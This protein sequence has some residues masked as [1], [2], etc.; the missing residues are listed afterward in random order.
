MNLTYLALLVLPPLHLSQV[1]KLTV[2]KIRVGNWA[3][4][5]KKWSPKIETFIGRRI[6][7]AVKNFLL[8]KKVPNLRQFKRLPSKFSNY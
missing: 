2:G 1:S 4:V 7:K 5:K 3:F 6:F 8:V